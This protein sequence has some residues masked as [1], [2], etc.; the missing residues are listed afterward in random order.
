ML[1]NLLKNNSISAIEDQK[2]FDATNTIAVGI[3]IDSAPSKKTWAHHLDIQNTRLLTDFWPHGAVAQLYN[4]FREHAGTS[5]RAN[6]IIDEH[7]NIA[8]NKI[9]P[10]SQLPDIKE[11][12]QFL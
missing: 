11:I 1:K 2:K 6:I 4:I 10:I 8:F 7:Q 9:Y 12:I 5:E 3:S